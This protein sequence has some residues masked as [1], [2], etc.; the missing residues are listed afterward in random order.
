MSDKITFSVQTPRYT[1]GDR[2]KF[3]QFRILMR[4]GGKV[5]GKEDGERRLHRERKT[6]VL[7]ARQ[8]I[9][10]LKTRRLFAI[11]VTKK[12]IED[13]EERNCDTCAVSQALWHNQN[14]MGLSRGDWNFRVEP[15]GA[16]VDFHGIVLRPKYHSGPET[17]LGDLPD[18]VTSYR[19]GVYFESMMEWTMSW[20]DW[21]ESRYMKI[22][23]WREMHGYEDGE[24]PYRPS[25]CS[26]VLDLDAFKPVK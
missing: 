1:Y 23:D 2:K 4:C 17:A 7:A 6:A 21:A 3:Y 26:F 25:P 16:W 9:D 15:Y 13:G 8:R 5:V 11:E 20:D 22:A 18:L 19:D 10:V 14:R 12:H 24:R